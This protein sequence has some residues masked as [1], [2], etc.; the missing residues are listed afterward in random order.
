[1]NRQGRMHGSAAKGDN[2]IRNDGIAMNAPIVC[3]NGNTK[4]AVVV[5]LQSIAMVDVSTAPFTTRS[6]VSYISRTHTAVLDGNIQFEHAFPFV[7]TVP[8]QDSPTIRHAK[9][10]LLR[11]FVSQAELDH[12]R[13]P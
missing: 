6:S 3:A 13:R 11:R 7:G 2:T 4:S 12:Y 9:Q 10:K 1:M 5:N 8:K